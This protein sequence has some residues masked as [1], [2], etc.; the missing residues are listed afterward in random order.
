MASSVEQRMAAPPLN[1]NAACGFPLSAS[2]LVLPGSQ[3][4]QLK[5]QQPHKHRGF[6]VPYCRSCLQHTA[7]QGT[8]DTVNATSLFKRSAL[9]LKWKI[10]IHVTT[11]HYLSLPVYPPYMST[12]SSFPVPFST[13][14]ED[15]VPGPVTT[16]EAVNLTVWKRWH[17]QDNRCIYSYAAQ[18]S[19]RAFRPLTLNEMRTKQNT[20]QKL[21]VV[22]MT[23]RRQATVNK[24]RQSHLLSFF[25]R[26]ITHYLHPSSNYMHYG[27]WWQIAQFCW[28]THTWVK[29]DE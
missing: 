21:S 18:H 20:L 9:Q 29:L 6:R 15:G 2:A 11:A 5:H 4:L 17:W 13:R 12:P 14:S 8:A 23:R 22:R 24:V 19:Y 16:G 3:L 28:S 7:S 27:R 26:G 25:T 10:M 1:P